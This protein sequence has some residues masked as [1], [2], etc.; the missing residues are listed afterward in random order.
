MDG[1]DADVAGAVAE[2]E[3][4]EVAAG[5]RNDSVRQPWRTKYLRAAR[6]HAKKGSGCW[7]CT[8]TVT[9][10]SV[11]P[12]ITIRVNEAIRSFRAP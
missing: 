9:G 5:K 7:K 11:A 2:V 6:F 1:C 3:E 8:P 12:A 10:F 4:E